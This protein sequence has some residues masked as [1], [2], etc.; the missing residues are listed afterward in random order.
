MKFQIQFQKVRVQY[1][2]Y[3]TRSRTSAIEANFVNHKLTLSIRLRLAI[4]AKLKESFIP[5]GN[6]PPRGSATVR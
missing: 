3:R 2:L 6:V 1:A 5:R 4:I